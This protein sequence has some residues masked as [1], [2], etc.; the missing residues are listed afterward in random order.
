LQSE[1][2]AVHGM[3]AAI[4]IVLDQHLMVSHLSNDSDKKPNFS[5]MET[6]HNSP[7]YCV[8]SAQWC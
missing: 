1:E 8:G 2:G 4:E 6:Q 3:L 5:T 7:C